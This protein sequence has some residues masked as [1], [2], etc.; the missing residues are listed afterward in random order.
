VNVYRASE[1]DSTI[2][3]IKDRLI[4]PTENEVGIGTRTVCVCKSTKTNKTD[5]K[6][7]SRR[8]HNSRDDDR[9]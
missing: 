7:G 3:M 5:R 4:N 2:N 1:Y 9:R 6:I 8:R